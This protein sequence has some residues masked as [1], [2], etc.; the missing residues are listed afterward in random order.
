M[1]FERALGQSQAGMMLQDDSFHVVFEGFTSH[2][3]RKASTTA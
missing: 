3:K 1:L 2:F